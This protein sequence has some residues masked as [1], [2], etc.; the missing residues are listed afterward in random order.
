MC[1]RVYLDHNVIADVY[2]NRRDGLREVIDGR[3][4]AGDIFPYSP[5]HME[6]IA[7]VLRSQ[8]DPEQAQQMVAEQIA[9]VAYLSDTWEIL[10]AVQN[11]GPSRLLREHPSLCM[12]RVTENYDLTLQGEE[13]ERS[14][15]SWKSESAFNQVQEDYGTSVRADQGVE[16]FP[17]KRQRL[18]IA[19]GITDV[20][21][22][23][24]FEYAGVQAILR[25][26][27]WNY[28]WKLDTMPTGEA[29]IRSHIDRQHVVNL[30]LKVLERAGYYADSANKHRSHL[31]DVSHAIYA[32]AA[33]VLVTGDKRYAKRVLAAYHYLRLQTRVV[34]TED[35]VRDCG[36]VEVNESGKDIQP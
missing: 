9:L 13:L 1:T 8:P 3:K 27:L 36:S 14:Q 11:A 34:S 23:A 16:L 21:P 19:R 32:A 15:H 2:Q 28:N 20:A 24:V 29:L 35:F 10:P 25:E 12:S 7:V 17:A 4:K 31:H 5:A 33:D 22:E 30:L 6:E 26:K 18:G